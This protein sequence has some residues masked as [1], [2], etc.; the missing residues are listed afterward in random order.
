MR[1]VEVKYN[2]RSQRENFFILAGSRSFSQT[3]DH[4]RWFTMR[5]VEVKYIHRSQRRD[6]VVCLSRRTWSIWRFYFAYSRI[7]TSNLFQS[8]RF[9]RMSVNLA[10]FRARDRVLETVNHR[11]C[12]LIGDCA[13][14]VIVANW[15]FVLKNSR[16]EL[17]TILFLS[18]RWS[19]SE[20]EIYIVRHDEDQI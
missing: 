13:E 4:S 8:R 6:F 14:D 5:I 16:H 7:S 17:S 11:H 18:T 10:E 20:C 12:W 1:Q 3:H 2:H 9:D 15:D 19:D